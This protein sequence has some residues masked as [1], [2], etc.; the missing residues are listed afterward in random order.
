MPRE[1]I[2]NIAK[3][4]FRVNNP[5]ALEEFGGSL[6]LTDRWARDVVKQLKLANAKE[7][8]VKLIRPLNFW[9][10]RSSAFKGK[11]LRQF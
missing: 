10:K 11:Y 1:Q 6:G 9:L 8:L 4:V 3:G 5:N 2:L 7:P